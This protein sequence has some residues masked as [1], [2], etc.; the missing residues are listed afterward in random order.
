MRIL[1]I[2]AATRQCSVALCIDGETRERVHGEPR[3]HARHLLPF[4]D[5]LLAEAGL[6]LTDL[7]ALAV[8]RG[9][10]S[11]TGVRAAI[12]AVQGL[13]YG[14][15]LPVAVV[16]SLQVLAATAQRHTGRVRVLALLDARME[17]VYCGCFDA[18][19][20]VGQEELCAPAE[21]VPPAAWEPGSWVAA[22]SGLAYG[23]RLPAAVRDHASVD[24]ESL[25]PAARDLAG[26]AV[27]LV[28][29][30]QLA[31]RAEAVQPV[32]LRDRVVHQG[33]KK[34]S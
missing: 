34:K 3:D 33:S 32:Y 26:L 20:A 22:G 10:G 6:R 14:S 2:E 9:P 25:C 17:E 19:R 21:A 1:A 27:P 8:G 18:A 15:G 23:E 7:D 11:F 13:A 30:K 28:Q 29:Q 12:S 16:S 24:G 31:T 5:Q 4:V